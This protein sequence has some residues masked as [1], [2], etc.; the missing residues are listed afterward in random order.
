M[1]A[2]S[3]EKTLKKK[4]NPVDRSY[5]SGTLSFFFSSFT[6]ENFLNLQYSPS[7]IH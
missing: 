6:F 1:A 2:I 5:Q 3:Q 4:K 7:K